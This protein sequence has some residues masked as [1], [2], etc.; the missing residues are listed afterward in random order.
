MPR[1]KVSHIREVDQDLKYREQKSRKE[2]L[3]QM[4]EKSLR[5]YL[6]EMKWMIQ[7]AIYVVKGSLFGMALKQVSLI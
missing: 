7:E 4:N 6:S 5:L 2:P 3:I 1:L